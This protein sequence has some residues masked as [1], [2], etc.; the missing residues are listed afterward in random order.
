MNVDPREV[1]AAPRMSPG[2]EGAIWQGAAAVTGRHV[3]ITATSAV[4]DSWQGA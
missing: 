2:I 1:E 4:A 3:S